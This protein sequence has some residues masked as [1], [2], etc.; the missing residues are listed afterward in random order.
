M[1][2]T[3]ASGFRG[4]VFIA[5]VDQ[6]GNRLAH[7][8]RRFGV[9]LRSGRTEKWIFNAPAGQMKEVRGVVIEHYHSPKDLWEQI[10]K[11]LARAGEA[12]EEINRIID[13]GGQVLTKLKGLG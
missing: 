1:L 4:A 6:K 8:L 5:L 7:G 10:Q 2:S 11:F 13:N 9:N 12:S 3:L